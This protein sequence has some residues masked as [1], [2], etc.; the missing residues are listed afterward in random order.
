MRHAQCVHA[1]CFLPGLHIPQ[2]EYLQRIHG[3]AFSF[4]RTADCASPGSR[5]AESE[6][7]RMPSKRSAVFIEK[8]QRCIARHRL[9]DLC[10][11]TRGS[12]KTTMTL[13]NLWRLT[14]HHNDP[15]LVLHEFSLRTGKWREQQAAISWADDSFA[16]ALQAV[17]DA[18]RGRTD[19]VDE[20]GIP[21]FDD[22]DFEMPIFADAGRGQAEDDHD[23][24]FGVPSQLTI[25][26]SIAYP[27][28][29]L[30]PIWPRINVFAPY[31][32]DICGRLSL[33]LLRKLICADDASLYYARRLIIREKYEA[34]QSILCS[35]R[36]FSRFKSGF[37][38]G[39]VRRILWEEFLDKKLMSVLCAKNHGI[40]ISLE[41]YLAALPYA[42]DIV[43]IAGESRGL[44]PLLNGIPPQHWGR[45]DLFSNAVLRE[46]NVVFA[47]LGDTHLRRLRTLPI[48]V[49]CKLYYRE[50]L[51]DVLDLLLG[52]Q[53]QEKI[54]AAIL[55]RV[56]KHSW[57]PFALPD[58]Y[59]TMPELQRIYRLYIR[60]CLGL[61]KQEGRKN[62]TRYLREDPDLSR[63]M[64]WFL[65][66]GRERGLPDKNATWDSLRR[67]A[68]AWHAQPEEARTLD[69][70][71]NE[72]ATTPKS[73]QS[74]LGEIEIAGVNVRP[75]ESELALQREGR[76]ML[77]CVAFYAS[78]CLEHNFRI[79][80]LAD[81]GRGMRST[82]CIR[83][84][85]SGRWMVYQHQG[86]SNCEVPP[87]ARKIANTVCRLYEE[88]EKRHTCAQHRE[89]E[90]L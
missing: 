88:A 2:H 51:R 79:F 86:V 75:L 43:R 45:R 31:N 28:L 56:V 42:Q 69:N 12:G 27:E 14:K 85:P 21:V 62:L 52:I 16:G 41:S 64:D 84:G 83:P 34:L 18:G 61:W 65:A 23:F 60:H 49:L 67:T 20:F 1:Q 81:E 39:S 89:G 7:F 70:P 82:L 80:S 48:S 78:Q 37:K 4:P 68:V 9:M 8:L 55:R 66:E 77:H 87:P 19:D 38:W 71:D 26:N 36:D 10:V 30:Q 11:I 50:R 53:L 63:I 57:R 35:C 3:V 72:A 22:H 54:P 25:E 40:S 47:G 29:F 73:W 5:S 74:L 6:D 58:V 90:R 33:A 13:C 76:D 44:L 17:A 46:T 59:G 32:D 15:R 24:D